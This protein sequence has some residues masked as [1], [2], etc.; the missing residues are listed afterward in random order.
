MVK[1][2][3]KIDS[4]RLAT[5]IITGPPP[6][7]RNGRVQNGALACGERS[8]FVYWRPGQLAVPAVG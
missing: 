4:V 8:G 3:V 5:R 7:R 6:P 2:L 1:S